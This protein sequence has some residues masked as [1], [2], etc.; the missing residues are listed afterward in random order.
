MLKAYPD[1]TKADWIPVPDLVGQALILAAERAI[2]QM[3]GKRNPTTTPLVLLC[4][5]GFVVL[6]SATEN[7]TG[8]GI[9]LVTYRM[10]VGTFQQPLNNPLLRFFR[11]ARTSACKTMAE[12]ANQVQQAAGVGEVTTYREPDAK[13]S[14]LF[15]P[16]I[17]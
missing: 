15:D 13:T 3:D 17:N 4:T 11:S 10:P 6:C 16:D 9:P 14:D 7:T 8:E 12:Q 2:Q 1:A 5:D